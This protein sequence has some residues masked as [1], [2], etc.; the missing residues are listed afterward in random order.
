MITWSESFES[1]CSNDLSNSLIRVGTLFKKKNCNLLEYILSPLEL[2]FL[3]CSTTSFRYKCIV[4]KQ[5]QDTH[6]MEIWLRI[7]TLKERPIA[8]EAANLKI[9]DCGEMVP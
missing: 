7:W 1:K 2:V 8:K 4:L 6:H 9:D 5:L 3:E